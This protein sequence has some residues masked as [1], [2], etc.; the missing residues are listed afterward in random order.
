MARLL[1]ARLSE[2]RINENFYFS[3]G[4]NGEVFWLYCLYFSF[5]FD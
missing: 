4:T 1:K 2:L 3:F 5:E